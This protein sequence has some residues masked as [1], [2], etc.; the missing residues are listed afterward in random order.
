MLQLKTAEQGVEGYL[1]GY[2]LSNIPETLTDIVD[3][4]V[5]VGSQVVSRTGDLNDPKNGITQIVTNQASVTATHSF[6]RDVMP[7]NGW[8]LATGSTESSTFVLLYSKSSAQSEISISRGGD[9]TVIV[10]NRTGR[11]HKP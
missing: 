9:A 1:S 11:E 6:Y 7:R 2:R 8:S 4:P 5:M 3:I 10:I